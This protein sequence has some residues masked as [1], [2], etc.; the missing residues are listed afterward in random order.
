M[1]QD[2]NQILCNPH[3]VWL[4]GDLSNLEETLE[5]ALHVSKSYH[6]HQDSESKANAPIVAFHFRVRDTCKLKYAQVHLATILHHAQR[7]RSSFQYRRQYA[8]GD[9]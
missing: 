9:K 1:L 2:N 6:C 5:N 3:T 7:E 4:R 8:Q